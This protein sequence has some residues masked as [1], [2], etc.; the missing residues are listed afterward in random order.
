MDRV[1]APSWAGCH[2]TDLERFVNDSVAS[3]QN[4]SATQVARRALPLLEA[5]DQA[6][7]KLQWDVHA[8][9]TQLARGEGR[10]YDSA[11]GPELTH[12]VK[13]RAGTARAD[14]R[15]SAI[16]RLDRLA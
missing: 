4:E 10:G 12:R 2:S 5:R 8:R 14:R 6:R 1:R 15:N 16:A 9:F 7:R 11:S 13:L 3:G